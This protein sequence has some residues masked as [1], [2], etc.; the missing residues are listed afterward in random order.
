ML[1][2]HYSNQTEALLQG[3]VRRLDAARQRS[4]LDPV[5]IVVPNRNMERYLELGVA[6]ALGVAANLTFH[7]LERFVGRWL[8][9]RL[10]DVRVAD[11][12]LF[13]TRVLE[14]LLDDAS[15]ETE[16]LGPVRAYLQAAGS[17]ADAVDVRRV[18]LALRL[19]ALF[20]EY[21]VSRPR[22]VDAWVEG[23]PCDTVGGDRSDAEGWQR[24]LFL[25][26]LQT[27]D[28]AR[29]L[30]MHRAILEAARAD[31]A[32]GA[33]PGDEA[34]AEVHVFGMSYAGPVFGWA[35][36]A[37]GR[38]RTV[39]VY[40]LNPCMEFWEDVP[41]AGELRVRAKLER[42][43]RRAAAGASL[44]SQE[45]RE[46]HPLLAGGDAPALVLWG[47]PGR[48]HVHMLD[49]LTEC[50]FE[51]LF[52]DPC[53]PGTSLLRQLQRDILTREPERPAP[54]P[55]FGF[56]SDTSVQV[57]ACPGVRREVESVAETIWRLVR[58]SEAPGQRPLR[59]H[60]IAVLVNGPD[61]AT[62]MPHIQAAFEEA[63][64]IPHTVIDLPL[65]SASRIAEAAHLLLDL[66]LGRLSRPEVL[67]VITHPA[68]RGRAPEVDAAAWA[69]LVARLGIF[70]GADHAAHAGTYIE[71]DVL[72]WDQGV[73]RLALGA[74]MTGEASGEQRAF[75]LGPEGHAY[76]PEELGEPGD[77][78]F[79][80]LVRSLLEDVRFARGEH[81]PMEEWARF[82]AA[83]VSS[84]VRP[85]SEAEESEL[86]RCLSALASLGERHL[87]GRPVSYRVALELGRRAFA[88]LSGGRGEYLT[89]GVSVST[90]VPMRAIPF[91]VVFVLGL[92]EGR[93]P[94]QDGRDALDLRGARRQ[95][96]DV[97]PTERDEYAF[98][99]ALLC[100]R[101]ALVLSYVARDELAGDAVAPSPVVE[102]LLD[103]IDAGYVRGARDALVR[104]LPLRRFDGAAVAEGP[105]CL[106]EAWH[107][108]RARA[109]GDGW[110]A[111]HGRDAS[112]ARPDASRAEAVEALRL[113]LG[114]AWA[115]VGELL[116]VPPAT[117]TPHV[118]AVAGDAEERLVVPAT[119]LR[120]F[121]ECP[122]QTWARTVA[123]VGDEDDGAAATEE[124]EPF[125]PGLREETFALRRV[126]LAVLRGERTLEDA[127]REEVA[128]L[129][130]R[131]QWPTGALGAQRAAK[132]AQV[133]A[134][135]RAQ[136]GVLGLEG[137]GRP[138]WVRLGPDREHGDADR[139]LPPL[140]WS[141]DDPRPGRTGKVRLEVTGRTEALFEASRVSLLLVPRELD[142]A[143]LSKTR[144]LRHALRGFMDHVLLCASGE[145][146][147]HRAAV[148]DVA[149]EG[150]EDASFRSPITFG[151]LEAERAR[152][153]LAA[154]VRELYGGPH[155][156]FLPCEAVLRKLGGFA[157]L[158]AA[159]MA[160][161]IEQVRGNPFQ[162]GSSRFGPV[163]DAVRRPAPE[164]EE[165][166]AMVR[167]RFGLF[168]ELAD[169][170]G[171]Q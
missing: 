58:A 96:G 121:L 132:D 158:D 166:L 86:R 153:W 126:L 131:G 114:E 62:Y 120:A 88:G 68:V 105:G 8:E 41:S 151:E 133:F 22:M 13:E 50:D 65:T 21:C 19:G 157:R 170:G 135:W 101:E 63:Q 115:P 156:Y 124:D 100:A 143:A 11:R 72:N 95:V 48:E 25:R 77:A 46:E 91:R 159:A 14:A 147:T 15:L 160:E 49:E 98:L 38:E 66:P 113:E 165:A 47:R 110:R 31:E 61:R 83:M 82:M 154:R 67:D 109:L 1:Y 30:P 53:A 57:L 76:F 75:S 73:R 28:E 161:S 3:L 23:R 168:F 4:P 123:G 148:V 102:R 164:P 59:F 35:L 71:R 26:C 139:V 56:G 150:K 43:V 37:L 136:L 27:G 141:M 89:Q 52:T 90:L 155:A 146:S 104:E 34:D 129:E 167:G 7:R 145:V 116:R 2:V 60:E 24:T 29:V 54:D 78:T 85:A 44:A 125:S 138:Q 117:A 128:R 87:G 134:A 17:D 84:Y 112:H 18:Q 74:F 137:A 79:A 97:S 64:R 51:P 93:F 70:H 69:H 80:L 10:G 32:G 33:R 162:G 39:R 20:E 36:A 106:P 163:P 107:E 94:A 6:Q 55:A 81:L 130:A 103:V 127:Y 9:G 92:S 45:P 149:R 119:S 144:R 171:L 12:A 99:E 118:G 140:T 108:A 5:E 152:G 16:A 169:L 142:G 42:R 40:A 111:H 122:L